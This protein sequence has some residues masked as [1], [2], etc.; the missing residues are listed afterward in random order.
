MILD[1]F[2]VAFHLIGREGERRGKVFTIV[3]KGGDDWGISN[4]FSKDIIIA[5]LFLKGLKS[6]NTSLL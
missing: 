2:L 6:I 5:Y 1:Q 4:T 3:G